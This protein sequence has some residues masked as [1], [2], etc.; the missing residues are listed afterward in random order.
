MKNNEISELQNRVNPYLPPSTTED[1]N[2]LEKC[3]KLQEFKNALLKLGLN[4]ETLN[5]KNRP[6]IHCLA[7]SYLE[8]DCYKESNT[9]SILEISQKD[10]NEI[11]VDSFTQH[12]VDYLDEFLNNIQ[13]TIGF[14]DTVVSQTIDYLL[15]QV[16]PKFGFSPTPIE[17]MSFS[18]KKLVVNFFLGL[19]YSQKE[20]T[21]QSTQPVNSH[22]R[23]KIQISLTE[24]V[25]EKFK[26]DSYI[27]L[28]MQYI[29]NHLSQLYSIFHQELNKQEN[30]QLS[31]IQHKYQYL[32]IS[33]ISPDLMKELYNQLKIRDQNIKVQSYSAEFKQ[34][35]SQKLDSANILFHNKRILQGPDYLEILTEFNIAMN[36]Y[37]CQ[38][39]NNQKEYYPQ[40]LDL[41]N[42]LYFEVYANILEKGEQLKN[43]DK[44]QNMMAEIANE[45]I[46]KELKF[47]R[48]VE[49]LI[50]KTITLN[51]IQLKIFFLLITKTDNFTAKLRL[52]DSSNQEN[53][54]HIKQTLR[55]HD[56]MQKEIQDQQKFQNLPIDLQLQQ[57][58]PQFSSENQE[59]DI[60]IRQYQISQSLIQEFLKCITDKL[61]QIVLTQDGTVGASFISVL[62]QYS[63]FV[64]EMAKDQFGLRPG[65][66]DFNDSV[67]LLLARFLDF[68]ITLQSQFLILI[69]HFDLDE[70]LQHAL[71]SY[72]T[73]LQLTIQ[74]VNMELLAEF[75]KPEKIQEKL[76]HIK[77]ELDNNQHNY[78]KQLR[79]NVARSMGADRGVEYLDFLYVLPTHKLKVD[80]LDFNKERRIQGYNY[81]YYALEYVNCVNEYL[82][83]VKSPTHINNQQNIIEIFHNNIK[84][85]LELPDQQNNLQLKDLHKVS[86]CLSNNVYPFENCQLKKYIK[87][88]QAT[89]T[90]LSNQEW[91]SINTTSQNSQFQSTQQIQSTQHA[92]ILTSTTQNTS[93]SSSLLQ[94]KDFENTSA[95]QAQ[96]ESN[97]TS[98]NYNNPYLSLTIEQKQPKQ[99]QDYQVDIITTKDSMIPNQTKSEPAQIGFDKAINTVK[100]KDDKDNYN[101]TSS[102]RLD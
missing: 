89:A 1:T 5:F 60:I 29:Q 9:Y 88:T 95:I 78:F 36:S 15:N 23:V 17:P 73:F 45:L 52:Q 61:V 33:Q 4:K 44:F 97:S 46:D 13:Q 28:S 41:M 84:Y 6:F 59:S 58:V 81:L 80:S 53:K 94:Q 42:Q 39:R 70:Y 27:Y 3:N 35:Q 32:Q 7:E 67:P 85:I 26:Q 40:Y 30:F 21:Q 19:F 65:D 10:L 20:K 43:D 74:T 99:D 57:N 49:I 47:Q 69:D 91:K 25:A 93:Q 54:L 48:E 102:Y 87:Q 12:F 101:Q 68:E 2:Q 50:Q 66:L 14:M 64:T 24:M 31:A 51:I 90:Q 34:L 92:Y 63:A 37:I 11:P 86:E 100:K 82:C 96:I 71:Q 76:S 56:N 8:T 62:Q 77:F 72:K 18:G 55:S 22:Q 16:H 98:R 38:Q 75:P 83:L 79:Y